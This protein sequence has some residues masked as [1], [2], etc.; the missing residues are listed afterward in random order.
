MLPSIC[1]VAT[2]VI[3]WVITSD[4]R[5]TILCPYPSH[6]SSIS[7]HSDLRTM[8]LHSNRS[9]RTANAICGVLKK[10]DQIVP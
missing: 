2:G 10:V 3:S 6:G 7:R 1:L 4:R 9:Y 5:L 8:H